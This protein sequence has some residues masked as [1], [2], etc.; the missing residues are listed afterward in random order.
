[1]VFS[2]V[3]LIVSLVVSLIVFNSAFVCRVYYLCTALKVGTNL[4]VLKE[5]SA[6]CTP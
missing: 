3:L 2:N 4:C 5:L 1:M 6:A